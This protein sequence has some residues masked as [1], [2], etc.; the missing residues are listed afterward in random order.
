MSREYLNALWELTK[1]E[2]RRK[3]ARSY[4]G[5]L[6]SVFYPLMRMALVVF[7]FTHIFNKG[8]DRYPAYYF[9]GFLI[10]EFF[11]VAVYTSITTLRDNR[12]LLVKTKLQREMFVLSRVLTAFVNFILGCI[13]YIGVLLVYK[14]Q[15][16]FM[17]FFVLIDLF[18]LLLFVSGVSYIVSILYVNLKDTKNIVSQALMIL[19]YFVAI[20]Y[21]KEWVSPGVQTF[22]E[23]NPPFVF[24]QIARDTVIY[25]VMP[26]SMYIWQMVL[27][28]IGFF[29]FGKIYFNKNKDEV[30]MRL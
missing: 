3:Y 8:I 30:L 22:I 23:H 5:I 4:L 2:L 15:F 26:D 27:Y 20:F 11:N 24:I 19:R 6:W 1:R 7:L 14:A 13:P 16:S 21:L 12:D 29:V 18:F 25:G 28:G 9:T 10:Y 17:T